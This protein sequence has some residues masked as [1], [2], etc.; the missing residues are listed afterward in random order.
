[1][2]EEC[3]TEKRRVAILEYGGHRDLKEAK[4]LASGYLGGQCS[5]QG[6]NSAKALRLEPAQHV[7]GSA[8][9]TVIKREC[10]EE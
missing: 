3:W 10:G 6:S 4:E 5:R 8:E 9:K 2:N 1:M 7:A